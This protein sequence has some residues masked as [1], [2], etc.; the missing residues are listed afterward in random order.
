MTV[1]AFGVK[2]AISSN[3]IPSIQD[4]T[5]M[6]SQSQ[7]PTP[8]PPSGSLWIDYAIGIMISAVYGIRTTEAIIH[9][10]EYP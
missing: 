3:K 9:K 1:L 7:A 10:Y 2:L 8:I 4:L 5:L 6:P